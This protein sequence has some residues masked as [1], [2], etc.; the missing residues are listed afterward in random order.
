MTDDWESSSPRLRNLVLSD[1]MTQ[2]A[3]RDIENG[4]RTRALLIRSTDPD[5]ADYPVP[6]T[7]LPSPVCLQDHREI[8]NLQ[9]LLNRVLDKLSLDKNVVVYCLENVSDDFVQNYLK[10][11]RSLPE[12]HRTKPI[13]CLNRHDFM[14]HSEDH[15][16]CLHGCKQFKLVE[17]NLHSIC[18]Q[19]LS[20]GVF[21]HHN[22]LLRRFGIAS[23]NA[24]ANM[25]STG[26]FARG[27]VEAYRLYNTSQGISQESVTSFL[28]MVVEDKDVSWYYDQQMLLNAVELE[29]IPTMMVKS[30]ELIS[31]YRRDP[32]TNKLFVGN[33]EIAIVYYQTFYNPEN[34]TDSEMWTLRAEME[35][36]S[37]INV[38]NVRHTLVNM[39]L[40]QMRLS[41]PGFLASYTD[42]LEEASK[43]SS[44]FYTTLPLDLTPEGDRNAQ[45]GIDRPGDYVLK[46]QREGGG[47]NLWD[48]ALV[49][50]L[51]RL[52]GDPG[53]SSYILMRRIVSPKQEKKFVRR[54]VMSPI[55]STVSEFGF[56]SVYCT[57]PFGEVVMNKPVGTMVRTKDANDNE[58]GIGMGIAAIDS[59]LFF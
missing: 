1:Y 5:K 30:Q 44:L 26:G 2:S 10:I 23:E 55:I 58:G 20:D 59:P 17:F 16:S 7:A 49:R 41:D 9:P 15:D 36:S 57:C 11:Y 33:K 51:E 50:E 8:E 34:F 19:S 24:K 43:L 52:S 13:L 14:Y 56:C 54:G 40:F 38:P 31:T 37:A 39:K 12:S 47:N 3:V 42:S 46:P 6:V 27:F 29:G 25:D 18:F 48:G 22:S 4:L 45:L 28:M 32:D 53:R 21:H 35:L